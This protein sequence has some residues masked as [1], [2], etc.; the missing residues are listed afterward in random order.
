M[1]DALE[2]V[3]GEVVAPEGEVGPAVGEHRAVV[4]EDDDA[5]GG[6]GGVARQARVDAAGLEGARVAAQVGEPDAPGEAHL[7]AEHA[8][9]RGGVGARAAGMA[10]HVR[11][12][13]A[14]GHE[15]AERAD[16]EVVHHV[17]DDEDHPR[18]AHAAAMAPATDALPRA[19]AMLTSSER[20]S[21]ARCR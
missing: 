16:H 15:W 8:Q 19:T 21:V 6:G 18:A 4:G 2:Q 3:V 12:R 7:G 17:A 10:L 5:A 13:V 1:V 20:P 9:P 11:R 14:A